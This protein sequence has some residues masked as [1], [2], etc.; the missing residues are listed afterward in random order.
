MAGH[1]LDSPLVPDGVFV[2]PD[3]IY[4][5]HMNAEQAVWMDKILSGLASTS[6]HAHT[7][8]S[9]IPDDLFLFPSPAV[10]LSPTAP[11]SPNEPEVLVPATPP[12]E[13][14][15]TELL[16]FNGRSPTQSPTPEEQVRLER[17]CAEHN[18]AMMAEEAARL[19]CEWLVEAE[20][21]NQRITNLELQT[22]ASLERVLSAERE[23]VQAL[24][25]TEKREKDARARQH[26]EI[27]ATQLAHKPN[28]F[29][30]WNEWFE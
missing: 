14:P 5:L 19:S 8:L 25:R 26:E 7:L 24:Q 12:E 1:S 13:L 16:N 20:A 6:V 10:P 23:T 27:L 29:E 18:A 30:E 9:Q 11:L 22:L 3:A 2:A 28:N 17:E 21:T 15:P 4:K